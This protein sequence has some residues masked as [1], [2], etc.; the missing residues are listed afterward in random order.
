MQL[1][2]RS[3]SLPGRYRIIFNR[4]PTAIAILAIGVST[5]AAPSASSA[6]A[7][8]AAPASES[9][10]L[11]A[12]PLAPTPQARAS[13]TARETLGGMTLQQRIGQLIMVG[14]P[15]HTS[16]S[17]ALSAI[18]K[19]HVGSVIL[20]G[21][22]SA[23]VAATKKVTDTLQK[24]ALATSDG[25]P[26]LIAAD[27]EGGQ[28]QVLKG[29][30]FS[31]MPSALSQG[32]H[33]S[34]SQLRSHAATW[35]SQLAAAGVNFN[36]A[37]VADTVTK[38]FA[39]KNTPIGY[40]DRQYGYNPTDVGKRAT[41]FANGMWDAGIATSVK[42]FPGLGRVAG[43]TDT[44]T[45]VTDTVTTRQSQDIAAFRTAIA[46]GAKAVMVSSA[47]YSK[48]DPQ[49]PAVFSSVVM[50]QMLR[51]DLGFT[52]VIISDSLQA[53][54]QIQQ[55]TPAERALKFIGSGGD[56]IL[57]T[58]TS[59]VKPMYQALYQRATT[60][61]A[62]Q[63]RINDAALRVLQLKTEIGLLGD[64]CGFIDVPASNIHCENIRWLHEHHIAK[65]ADGLFHPTN[66]VTRGAMTAFLFRLTHP[67]APAPACTTQ[68]Y[69]DVRTDN[70]FCGYISWA[71][72]NRLIFGYSDGSFKPD[73]GVTRGA[74]AALIHRII[75]KEP[76]RSCF[77][78][79]FK[80]VPRDHQFCGAIAWLADNGITFG[81]NRSTDYAPSDPVTRE[82]MA[83]FLH[84]TYRRLPQH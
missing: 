9:L 2:R 67:G 3:R 14:T 50:E 62:F 78:P 11:S 43:N 34:L 21:R 81:V 41:A 46:A 5:L 60:D 6:A 48:I 70:V 56:L 26:L 25:I 37:P 19:Y 15:A 65:P 1:A 51:D 40:Y 74:M 4:L 54:R 75:T 30:G 38:V 77:A 58:G 45:N 47:I 52:G 57:T 12:A 10:T 22:S 72:A 55:W 42:H 35:G 39:P 36:L 29:P 63:N 73:N 27:Q 76:A 23:G 44:T 59:A 83:S 61:T 80:D 68:P 7:A 32:T 13:H 53:A 16:S 18:K 17:A 84:R 24:E 82:Q 69:Q 66:P 79:P 49:A 31:T 33:Y 20:T 8:P 71:K 28:V 64:N